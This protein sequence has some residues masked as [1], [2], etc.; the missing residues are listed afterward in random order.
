MMTKTAPTKST[1]P[2]RLIAK[3]YDDRLN[4]W[5]HIY[6]ATDPDGN[7]LEVLLTT[8]EMAK[9]EAG[10]IKIFSSFGFEPPLSN[11]KKAALIKLIEGQ[12]TDCRVPIVSKTGWAKTCFITP[13]GII[14]DNTLGVRLAKSGLSQQH[15]FAISGTLQ[16]WQDNILTLAEGN[17]LLMF[18][19]AMAFAPPLLSLT[20]SENGGFNLVLRSSRGKS[21]AAIF[22]GSVW[23]G[24]G[25]HGYSENWLTTA[26]NIDAMAS[27]YN[28]ALLVLDETGL[29]SEKKPSDVGNLVLN[30]AYRLTHGE[31][32]GRLTEPGKRDDWRLYY[33]S[34]S[35]KT[36][37]ELAA[38]AKIEIKTGQLVRFTDI[39]ADAGANMGLFENLHGLN[40]PADFANHLRGAALQYYGTAA[41]KFITELV[42]WRQR[43]AGS[44]RSWINDREEFYNKKAVK[45]ITSGETARIASRFALIYAAACLAKRFGILK[46]EKEQILDAILFAHGRVQFKDLER[47]ANSS[48][49]TNADICNQVKKSILEVYSDLVDLCESQYS[50]DNADVNAQIGFIHTKEN[51]KDEFLFRRTAFQKHCCGELPVDRI[52]RILKAEG[53]LN[54]QKG[55]KNT[56]T[57]K[58]SASFGRMRFI[59]I[60]AKIL[61]G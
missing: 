51:G 15:H 8:E 24:G 57:R 7:P 30:T 26:N 46:W 2:I 34:T 55:G 17:R 19:I 35:E 18:G 13:L 29:A 1:C 28:D 52:I 3:G 32:K 54:S 6:E 14:G 61:D 59:S 60:K 53:I 11:A 36:L 56:V 38:E 49:K 42:A 9:G 43:N 22:F 21:S 45:L 31:R 4:R 27:T 23:G 12:D 20:G 48:L 44:L 5:C 47:C 10:I 50:G 33:L 39:V 16:E 41:Q 58:I 40:S 25:Q 37:T